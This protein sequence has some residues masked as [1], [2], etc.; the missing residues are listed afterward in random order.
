MFA[1]ECEV[2]SMK[3]GPEVCNC[4]SIAVNMDLN[5]QWVEESQVSY[6]TRSPCTHGYLLQIDEEKGNH[7]DAGLILLKL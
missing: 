1:V 3:L 4:D 6:G 5:F 7:A 2:L